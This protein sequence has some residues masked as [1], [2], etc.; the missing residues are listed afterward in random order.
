MVGMAGWTAG[1]V[2]MYSR[3]KQVASA[4]LKSTEGRGSNTY[5]FSVHGPQPLDAGAYGVGVM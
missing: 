1:C 3:Q 5:A 4:L 2:A